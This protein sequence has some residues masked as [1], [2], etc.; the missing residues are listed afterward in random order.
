MESVIFFDGTSI[1]ISLV[2]AIYEGRGTT[3]Q[4]VFSITM[5]WVV[6]TIVI[7]ALS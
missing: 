3:V 5:G 4:L 1:Y 7:G 6:G 2:G